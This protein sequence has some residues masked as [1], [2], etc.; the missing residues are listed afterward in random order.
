[1]FSVELMDKLARQIEACPAPI[2][3]VAS[4]K[5]WAEDSIPR[6]FREQLPPERCEASWTAP[7]SLRDEREPGTPVYI[8]VR[9]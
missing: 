6:N 4:L 1:M 3:V 2:R 9:V 5:Q 8:Y 7:Q